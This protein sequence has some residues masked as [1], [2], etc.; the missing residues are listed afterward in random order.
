MTVGLA[1]AAVRLREHESSIRKPA[2]TRRPPPASKKA[3]TGSS[4]PLCAACRYSGDYCRCEGEPDYCFPPE[5]LEIAFK[6]NYFTGTGDRWG[7]CILCHAFPCR[8]REE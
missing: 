1:Q 5:F 8:C 6:R 4:E 3:R 7:V 2:G